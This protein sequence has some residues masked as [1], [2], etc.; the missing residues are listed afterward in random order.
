LERG[1]FTLGR[2]RMPPEATLHFEVELVDLR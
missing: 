2:D 1:A